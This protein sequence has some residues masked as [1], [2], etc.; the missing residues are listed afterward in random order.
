MEDNKNCLLN[1]NESTSNIPSEQYI[2]PFEVEPKER[3]H[4]Y[5]RKTLEFQPN[6]PKLQKRIN[7]RSKSIQISPLKQNK[8][9]NNFSNYQFYGSGNELF[10]NANL[11]DIPSKNNSSTGQQHNSS[12]QVESPVKEKSTKV[13]FFANRVLS[14]YLSSTF[15]LEKKKEFLSY[16]DQLCLQI[17]KN[18]QI[19]PLKIYQYIYE[20]TPHDNYLII[21]YRGEIE[22]NIDK[23]LSFNI[24]EGG[25]FQTK[26][27]TYARAIQNSVV[28]QIPYKKYKMLMD[29]FTSLENMSELNFLSK[30]DLFRQ[31]N[32]VIVEKLNT[33][34][35]KQRYN[36]GQI[37]TQQGQSYDGLYIIRKGQFEVN[38]KISSNVKKEY[39]IS[40]LDNIAKCP[41]G[42]FNSDKLLELKNSYNEIR[43]LKL[44]I[45]NRGNL[46][47]DFEIHK[48]SDKCFFTYKCSMDGSYVLFL[49]K[50]KLDTYFNE[51]VYKA[52]SEIVKNKEALFAQ[53]IDYLYQRQKKEL[54]LKNKFTQLVMY[55]ISKSPVMNRPSSEDRNKN[56]STPHNVN[57]RTYSVKKIK[58]VLLSKQ[59]KGNYN[60]NET[61]IKK[62]HSKL[63]SRKNLT[64]NNGNSQTHSQLENSSLMNIKEYDYNVIYEQELARSIRNIKRT[65]SNN[66]IYNEN[67]SS[68]ICP[69]IDK[70]S[71]KNNSH[72][73]FQKR[74][75]LKS[76]NSMRELNSTT[77]YFSG[78]YT[79]RNS[80]KKII[81]Y[82]KDKGRKS[83]FLNNQ[84]D[85]VKGVNMTRLMEL[86]GR[87]HEDISKCFEI[88][89]F[90]YMKN[91]TS[92]LEKRLR[93]IFLKKQS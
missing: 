42:L 27:T 5:K 80:T 88:N 9:K 58:P 38:L 73:L 15:F 41:E 32:R 83:N 63:L 47:N 71:T 79:N 35:E 4:K 22:K 40:A 52:L 68:I 25:H 21:V 86:N 17:I 59:N 72:I 55:K 91:N 57:M 11:Y 10:Q 76:S 37:I 56:K 8:I 16:G 90:F 67:N 2:T 93:D 6:I 20:K 81:E 24:Y 36:K 39:D 87:K 66:N 53:R 62:K 60:E 44:M 84:T 33:V 3:I 65:H 29:K 77:H 61:L 70:Q 14:S 51:N 54:K 30:L 49:P 23:T 28:F 89:K 12:S 46:I 64:F 45:L 26:G 18:S 48:K 1:N 7:N 13:N 43:M 75:L 85:Q 92:I 19:T 78:Q 82:S 31:C 69:M 74:T 34:L 50:D